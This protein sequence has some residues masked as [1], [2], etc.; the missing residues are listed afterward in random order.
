M[1]FFEARGGVFTAMSSGFIYFSPA[2][3]AAVTVYLAERRQRRT[4]GYYFASGLVA[5]I[6]FV[7]GTMLVMI[8]GLIC[9]VII[10]PLFAIIGGVVGLLMGAI[11]RA[12]NWP[13]QTLSS[14]VILPFLFASLERGMPL[15]ESVATVERTV[16]VDASPDKIW[17]RIVDVPEIRPEE[18]EKAWLYRIGV[19]LP[20]RGTTTQTPAGR[21]RRVE[22]G[23]GIYFDEIIT[24]FH[25]P[26][27][28]RWKFR[29]YD[30]SFPR[31]ALDEHVVIG[32]SYFDVEDM[33]YTLVPHGALTKLTVRMRYR[34][35]TRFNWYAVP[36]A[37]FL[38]GNLLESN[39]GYYRGRSES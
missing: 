17:R 16:V 6:L 12:T 1:A 5:N 30:D 31:Y 3:V 7:C 4:W 23:K 15:P 27:F 26:S 36:A 32:G 11:C 19:P 22:M 29:Y 37:R 14:L 13:K 35:S 25:E 18:V 2:V 24:E 21:V 10:A 28:L 34:V 8:E 39:L 20:V 33:S 38:M 9:A